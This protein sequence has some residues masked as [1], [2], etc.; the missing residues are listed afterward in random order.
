M[1]I[2]SPLSTRHQNKFEKYDLPLNIYT[3]KNTQILVLDP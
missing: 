1:K 3:L 2:I